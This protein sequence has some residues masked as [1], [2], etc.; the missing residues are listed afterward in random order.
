MTDSTGSRFQIFSHNTKTTPTVVS[1]DIPTDT[2]EMFASCVYCLLCDP[3]LSH[4]H[5]T[6]HVVT[7][8]LNEEPENLWQVPGQKNLWQVPGEENL[9]Q[10]PVPVKDP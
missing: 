9:W 8:I 5:C 10:A 1:L 3:T 4:H 7:G 2:G 6:S